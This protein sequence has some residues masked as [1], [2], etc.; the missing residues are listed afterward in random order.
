V[1]AV[2]HLTGLRGAA[3]L[4]QRLSPDMQIWPQVLHRA[5]ALSVVPAPRYLLTSKPASLKRD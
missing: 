3:Q 4:R 1:L 2:F 5:P